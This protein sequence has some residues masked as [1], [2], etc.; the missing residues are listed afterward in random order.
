MQDKSSFLFVVEIPQLQLLV[1]LN[2]ITLSLPEWT[3]FSNN[4]DNSVKKT[5]TVEKLSSNCWLLTGENQL[6][7]LMQMMTIAEKH[8]MKFSSLFLP[9]GYEVIGKYNKM[10]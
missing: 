5:S 9:N 10:L 1:P 8:H 6:H 4:V 7:V 2:G 3:A